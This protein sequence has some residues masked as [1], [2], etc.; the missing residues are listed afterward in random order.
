MRPP[1]P[2]LVPQ[3]S[4][5]PATAAEL[6]G[7]LGI[8]QSALSRAMLE[9][10]RED[11]AI[12]M[13]AA[14][15]TRYGLRR[16]VA[17]AGSNWPVFQVDERG[18]V[19][20][21]GRLNALQ[22][23]HFY[24]DSARTALRGLTDRV[25]YF[26][27]DQRPGGFLGR[28]VPTAY[29]K[30]ALPSRVVD[31]SDDHYLAYL[32][33]RGYDTVSDLIV[34]T[35][36]LDHYLVS[37]RE[38]R[39]IPTASRAAE[40][41]ALA[42]AA[43]AGTA[44]GSSAHGEQPKFTALLDNGSGRTHV[45]VKF[46]PPRTTPIGQRW[47]D[48]LVAEHLAH[49]HLGANGI[50]SCRSAVIE[51]GDRLFL[52]VERFDRVGAT[53]RRGVVSLLALDSARYG[54]LDRWPSSAT[55]LANDR[56]LS[57]EDVDRIRLLEAFGQLIANTDRH[58]GNLALFDHYDGR[59]ELAPIYDM[60]PMLFAPTNDQIV[61]REF[62]VPVATAETLSVWPRARE[63]AEGYWEMTSTDDR[64]SEA[65]RA[66]ANRVTDSLRAAAHLLADA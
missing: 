38:R 51:S 34:G 46:S 15:S 30:L 41:P 25:P 10:V 52:E 65:L 61:A 20:E 64:I 17:G 2:P 42:D 56:L 1:D 28:T 48:L 54:Q 49:V 57:P 66:M 16:S 6:I 3:L 50:A 8:S 58:F 36:A 60:L 21:I 31:W 55:R 32:T 26:L 14:R 13:G 29:P 59:F 47:A 4:A 33:R 35:E 7:A 11:R 9:L 43:M 45:I 19:N 63:L 22:Q 18:C 5:G 23:R 53:G 27:Q 62:P 44:P 40:Y 12:R 39:A 24:F 37:L